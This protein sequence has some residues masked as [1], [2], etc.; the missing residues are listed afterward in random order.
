MDMIEKVARAIAYADDEDYDLL[1]D[2]YN[3]Q[4]SAAI[5]AM[6]EPTEAMVEAGFMARER[7]MNLGEAT[8]AMWQEMLRSAI[9]REVGDDR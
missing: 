3:A 5:R 8:T 4:A 2:L 7:G 1:P 9:G 6:M